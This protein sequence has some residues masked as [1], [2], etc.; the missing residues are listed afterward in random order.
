MCSLTGVMGIN[1][2]EVDMKYP[3]KFALKEI[4]SLLRDNVE[5][6]GMWIPARPL[7]LYSIVNRFKL[8]WLVFTGKADVLVWP[9]GQ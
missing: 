4:P 5:Y 7:G 3:N 2:R 8:A 6:D 1:K 9:G